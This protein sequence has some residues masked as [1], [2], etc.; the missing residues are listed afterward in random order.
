MTLLELLALTSAVV[1][2]L[3]V[4]T[5]AVCGVDPRAPLRQRG[6]LRARAIEV[7]PYVAVLGV[8]YLFNRWSHAG[9]QRVS[10]AVG[11]HI[12]DALYAVEGE[13]V[14][15]LQA[16]I[17]SGLTGYFSFVYL[18]GFTFLLVFPILAYLAHPARWPLKELFVAYA[19]NYGVGAVC[20]VLF[21]ARGP[22]KV[23]ATVG[24]PMFERY[25]E[26]MTLTAAVNTSTNVFPSLHASL[27]VTVAL[28]AWRTRAR[29]RPWAWL[30]TFLAANVLVA[31]MYLGI[32]WL[33]DVV[34]GVALAVA[35]VLIALAVVRADEGERKGAGDAPRSVESP[36]TG[37]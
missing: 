11:L 31:T 17:P 36:S 35:S 23:L 2:G 16:A 13:F 14:A 29:Y 12:T 24:A 28:L 30:A 32:H 6:E 10:D 37:D 27:A 8:V 25:P 19:V 20:Y 15:A 9:G 21:V 7:G 34:A 26:V 22:R 5:C 1:V 3:A 18:F 33:V 4:P